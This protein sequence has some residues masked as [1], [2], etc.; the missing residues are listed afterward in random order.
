MWSYTCV[1]S[2]NNHRNL[3]FGPTW[4]LHTTRTA[5]GVCMQSQG[6][7][8]TA[9]F[10]ST[11]DGLLLWSGL[12]CI[13]TNIHKTHTQDL[14]PRHSIWSSLISAYYL[15]LLTASLEVLGLLWVINALADRIC[16]YEC[17]GCLV[18]VTTTVPLVDCTKGTAVLLK[19][20]WITPYK[21]Y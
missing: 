11:I 10:A 9:G 8:R 1:V 19:H 7:E 18:Y 2:S 6:F 16:Y 4:P 13:G 15:R 17:L 20:K 14:A 21:I 3:G 5:G 12:G